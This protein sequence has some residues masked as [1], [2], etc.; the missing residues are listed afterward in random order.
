VATRAEAALFRLRGDPLTHI[1]VERDVELDR[2][3]PFEQAIEVCIQLYQI[4]AYRTQLVIALAPLSGE[5]YR[6][7]HLID[8]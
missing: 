2:P 8:G 3:R 4:A 6:Y 7:G 5:H 1:A